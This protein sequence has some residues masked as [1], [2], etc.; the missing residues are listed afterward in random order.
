MSMYPMCPGRQ[1]PTILQAT[2]AHTNLEMQHAKRNGL[3]YAEAGIEVLISGSG[4]RESVEGLVGGTA[5]A[6]QNLAGF[7]I[8]RLC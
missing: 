4:M 2:A 6:A 5:L 7:Y 1:L 3:H 8:E